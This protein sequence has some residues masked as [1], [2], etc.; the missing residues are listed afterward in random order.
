MILH[1]A[2]QVAKRIGGT[3]RHCCIKI[4]FEPEPF[5]SLNHDVVVKHI[6]PFT[7]SD[8]HV[9]KPIK[10]KAEKKNHLSLCHLITSSGYLE[11]DKF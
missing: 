5:I 8:V 2:D 6:W 4:R 11:M 3:L 10:S 1:I 7:K 9:S